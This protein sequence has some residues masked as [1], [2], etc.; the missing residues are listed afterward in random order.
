M[1]LA[2][3]SVVDSRVKLLAALALGGL[4]WRASWPG[5]LCYGLFLLA[6]ACEHR[7][8]WPGNVRLLRTYVFF[9]LFWSV[10]KFALGLFGPI[11]WQQAGIDALLIAVRVSCL[12]LLGAAL[13]M[14]TTTRAMGLGLSALLGP[15]L[16][17]ERA[18][19][20]A[21]SFALMAHFLP[22]TW[23]TV[24]QVKVTVRQRC[25]KLKLHKRLPL[26][27][28]AILRN[29]GRLTWDQSLALAGRNLDRAE[30]WRTD[31]P[32][33]PWQWGGGLLFVVISAGVALL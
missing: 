11:S 4:I 1:G 12:L 8:A 24:E 32:F 26:M 9:V 6:V 16:G 31:L 22:M 15:L 10:A 23:R 14:T 13:T 30:A 17:R 2:S 33:F 29:L 7:H 19:K 21:L 20:L 27:V 18:W 25:P 3:L 5:L 28:Q